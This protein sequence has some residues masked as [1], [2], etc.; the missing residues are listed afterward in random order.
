MFPQVCLIHLIDDRKDKPSLLH[1]CFLSSIQSNTCPTCFYMYFH[2]Y[3]YNKAYVLYLLVHRSS[4]RVSLD[5]HVHDC[6]VSYVFFSLQGS[7]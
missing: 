7:T 6:N 3:V 4:T 1:Q 2:K 5:K